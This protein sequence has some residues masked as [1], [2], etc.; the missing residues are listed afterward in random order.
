MAKIQSMSVQEE[1]GENVANM[2]AKIYCICKHITGMVTITD[3]PKDL[4]EV[5]MQVFL[6]RKT[7]AFNVIMVSILKYTC[8]LTA[9]WNEVL[10]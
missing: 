8:T 5:C 3:I 7:T 2:T 4:P 6:N 1:L 10:A 9:T